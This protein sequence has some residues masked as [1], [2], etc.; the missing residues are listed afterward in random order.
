MRCYSS[1]IRLVSVRIAPN[2]I[3]RRKRHKVEI[4]A[5]EAIDTKSD[6]G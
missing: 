2:G 1:V 3:A 5:T 6:A 4:N